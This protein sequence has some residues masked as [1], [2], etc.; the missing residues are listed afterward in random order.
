MDKIHPDH[1]SSVSEK[2]IAALQDCALDIKDSLRISEEDK[3]K[4]EEKDDN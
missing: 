1:P 2:A 3:Q 4:Q